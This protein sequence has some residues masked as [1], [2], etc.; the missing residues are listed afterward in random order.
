MHGSIR[1]FRET[2]FAIH[3]Q[4]LKRN[5]TP[6]VLHFALSTRWSKDGNF[7]LQNWDVVDKMST[8]LTLSRRCNISLLLFTFLLLGIIFSNLQL[9]AAISF[10]FPDVP[11]LPDI[12][13]VPNIKPPKDPF[14]PYPPEP[15]PARI[16]LPGTRYLVPTRPSIPE[17]PTRTTPTPP[18][19]TTPTPPRITT[20]TP[21][22]IT[23]PTPPRIPP[24]ETPYGAPL[25][26]PSLSG[27]STVTT[28]LRTPQ[29]SQPSVTDG[30]AGSVAHTPSRIPPSETRYVPK[31]TNSGFLYVSTFPLST[32]PPLTHQPSPPIKPDLG[33]TTQARP[34]T[35][36]SFNFLFPVV[37]RPKLPSK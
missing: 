29:P 14:L 34:A 13:N 11:K 36:S 28:P 22:R 1:S 16:P 30:P 27:I 2:K 6:D 31:P 5:V 25:T 24:P 10:P 7:L 19:I 37:E 3:Q 26:K 20:P 17:A 23:T 15:T 21:P 12:P 35:P 4:G 32:K 9:C 33:S 8:Q 18:R